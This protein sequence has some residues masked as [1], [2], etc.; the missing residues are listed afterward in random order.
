MKIVYIKGQSYL[1]QFAVSYNNMFSLK[2]LPLI[3]PN[4]LKSNSLLSIIFIECQEDKDC[5]SKVCIDG[6]CGKKKLSQLLEYQI[7]YTRV[8]Y[9]IYLRNICL[10]HF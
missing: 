9:V 4:S 7:N 3:V 10:I 8:S 1:G 2:T 5:K 6:Y